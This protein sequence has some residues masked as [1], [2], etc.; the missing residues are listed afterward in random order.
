MNI[1]KCQQTFPSH[2]F[3]HIDLC[4]KSIIGSVHILYNA[5]GVGRGFRFCY[6]GYTVLYIVGGGFDFCYK[7][8]TFI[9]FNIFHFLSA[10]RGLLKTFLYQVSSTI[11]IISLHNVSSDFDLRTHN[12]LLSFMHIPHR[13]I[14]AE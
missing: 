14:P 7:Y 9:I 11:V 5:D 2:K 4:F 13:F 6:T 12:R 8:N 3:I 1:R 10:F